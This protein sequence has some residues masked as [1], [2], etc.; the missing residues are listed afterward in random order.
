MASVA[1]SLPDKVP[2]TEH[3]DKCVELGYQLKLFLNGSFRRNV[4]NFKQ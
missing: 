3:T 2:R 4:W 1:I